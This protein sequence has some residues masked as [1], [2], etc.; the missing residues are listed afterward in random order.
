MYKCLHLTP[1]VQSLCKRAAKALVSMH[2]CPGSCSPEPLLLDNVISNGTKTS[3]ASSYKQE[4]ILA[5]ILDGGH[6]YILFD[7]PPQV[8]LQTYN[9]FNCF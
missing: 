3:C 2:I 4:N 6:L 9:L 5:C 8:I 7:L 1:E